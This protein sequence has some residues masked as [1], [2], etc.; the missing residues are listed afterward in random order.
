MHYFYQSVRI[1][2]LVLV[3]FSITAKAQGIGIGTSQVE[4][5]VVLKLESENKGITVPNV[6][7]EAKNVQS[8]IVGQLVTG[9]LLYNTSDSGVGANTV[10]P[11]FYVWNSESSGSWEPLSSA[12]IHYSCKFTNKDTITDFNTGSTPKPLNIFDK[13]VYNE[14]T[15]LY[16]VL[17]NSAINIKDTGL[18]KLTLVLDM[19][20]DSD[21]DLFGID[22]YVNG[23]KTPET[24]YVATVDQATGSSQDIGYV[25][26]SY[27][28]I[29]RLA[30]GSVVNI[31]GRRIDGAATI[32][33]KNEG[34]SSI[35][36]EKIR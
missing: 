7:L 18:Y 9:V 33:F 21:R 15:D 25:F 10:K 35:V 23:Q 36:I 3:L 19:D 6:S 5:G 22:I 30:N 31:T 12:V 14:N 26:T 16:K 28:N 13:E 20:G 24:F 27:V 2:F 29:P 11:G 17:N 8:P 32:K 1:F 4:S 34:T